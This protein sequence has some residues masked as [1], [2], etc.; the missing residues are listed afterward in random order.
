MAM[1]NKGGLWKIGEGGDGM[2]VSPD[3]G[4]A[5]LGLPVKAPKRLPKEK[6][7]YETPKKPVKPSPRN[8]TLK[9]SRYV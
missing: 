7:R 2:E 4:P 6:F 8:D 3:F 9:K 5:D 1:K